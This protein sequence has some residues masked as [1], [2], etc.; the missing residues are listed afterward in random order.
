MRFLISVIDDLS[1]PGTSK[2]MEAIDAFNE[3]LVTNGHWLLAFGLTSPSHATVID[4]RDDLHSYTEAPLFDNQENMS[5]MW[6][7]EAPNLEVAR[8]LAAQGSKSCNRK[9]ELRPFL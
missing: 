3:F 9:V 6:I 4:N 2:E 7:I 8:E 1:Q 5:G